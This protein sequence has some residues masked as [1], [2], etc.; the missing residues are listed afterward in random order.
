MFEKTLT[1]VLYKN[2]MNHEKKVPYFSG[3]IQVNDK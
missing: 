2:V 3:N 1:Y